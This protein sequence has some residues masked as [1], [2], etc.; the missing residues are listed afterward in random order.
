MFRCYNCWKTGSSDSCIY[1]REVC[2]GI[3]AWRLSI[4][5]LKDKAFLERGSTINIGP[6]WTLWRGRVKDAYAVC[7]PLKGGRSRLQSLARGLEYAGR[8]KLELGD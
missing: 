2:A 8:G 7:V 3:N 5:S 6:T 4:A 1:V